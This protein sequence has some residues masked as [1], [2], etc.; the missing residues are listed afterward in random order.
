V[1]VTTT[2]ELVEVAQE[3]GLEDLSL[4]EDPAQALSPGDRQRRK[5]DVD[6]PAHSCLNGV[7]R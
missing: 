5:V 4:A 3:P 6:Q 2:S 1:R 7:A